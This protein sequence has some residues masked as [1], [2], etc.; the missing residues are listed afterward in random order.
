MKKLCISAAILG[1]I[2]FFSPRIT[3]AHRGVMYGFSGGAGFIAGSVAGPG[4][5]APAGVGATY[6]LPALELRFFRRHRQSFEVQLM[7]GNMLYGII[8]GAVNGGFSLPLQVGLYHSFRIGRGVFR[9]IVAPGAEI[10]LSIS[11]AGG[12][13]LGLSVAPGVRLGL[14]MA[15]SPGFRLEI[16]ARPFITAG[17]FAVASSVGRVIPLFGGGMLAELA[18]YFG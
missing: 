7:F 3:Q 16:R 5:L 14:E 13:A 10:D 18:L 11:I 12:L 8:A 9:F 6:V 4:G 15:F 1:S 17:I 2:L